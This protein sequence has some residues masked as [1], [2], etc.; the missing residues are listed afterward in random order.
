MG[1]TIW[2]LNLAGGRKYFCSPE[3]LDLLIGPPSLLFNGYQRSF[4]GGS[5]S[6]GMMQTT[7]H[8]LALRLRMCSTMP[9]LP[10]YAFMAK[11]MTTLPLPL[12]TNYTY[13]TH[14][15]SFPSFKV[16]RSL[17]F[18]GLVPHTNMNTLTTRTGMTLPQ[19]HEGIVGTDTELHSFL[20]T[21][22]KS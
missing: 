18:T 10:L 6:Q 19:H 12:L 3:H 15:V 14:N 16:L 21:D 4:L 22:A 2:G 11:T 20:A 1:S 9:L 17:V 13:S 5:S 8:H 7:L